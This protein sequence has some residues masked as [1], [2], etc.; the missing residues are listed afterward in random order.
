MVKKRI[1]VFLV[2]FIALLLIVA[3]STV[4]IQTEET[5][6]A[7]D[8]LAARVLIYDSQN[9]PISIPL[10]VSVE[11]ADKTIEPI[12]M[13]AN[14]NEE[15]SVNLG[16]NPK[17]GAWILTIKYT[18]PE[19]NEAVKSSRVFTVE[20]KEDVIFEI[21]GDKLIITN[22]GNVRY[23]RE[24]QIIIGNSVG[25]KLIDLSP[26]EKV[27]LRLIAPDGT[28]DIRILV[29]GQTKL[30]KG[31]VTLTGNVVGILDENILGNTPITG[32]PRAGGED[33]TFYDTIKDKKYIYVFLLA[34]IGAA[35]LLAVERSYKRKI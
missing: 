16:E 19:T 26:G 27:N 35:I 5:L 12:T 30:S 34:I 10:E 24:I 18:E 1:V 32:G 20:P 25:T 23:S 31:G 21:Q 29:D 8:S 22:N 4:D 15:F 17:A 13:K 2:S 14:S 28:Y 6:A 7:G 9:N 33:Q 3:A 11:D